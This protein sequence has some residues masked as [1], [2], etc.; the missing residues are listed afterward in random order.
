MKNIILIAVIFVVN[1]FATKIDK[2]VIA[3]PVATISHPIFHIIQE[4]ALK[5]IAE[6]VE[7]RLWQNPDEL[8]AILLKKEAHIVA[9]PTNVAANLY[10]K[11]ENIKLFNIPVWGILE[12]ITRDS[13]I[14]NINDLKNKEIVVP[15]RADMPDIMLQAIMKKE[16]LD[17]KK[18]FKLIYAPTPPDAMQMLILRRADN[19]LLAEPA[20]SM[21]MR[22]T[23]SFPLKLIAPDIYRSVNLQKEWGRVYGTQAKVPQAG[24]AALGDLDKN[25]I[26]R[27]NDEYTKSLNWYKSNPIEAG[28]LVAKN[29]DFFKAEAISDSIVNV[30]LESKTA[31]ESKKDLYDFFE[32]LKEIEPK[33]I[34]S[35]IPDDNFIW[36]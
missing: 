7:F 36:E 13:N 11:G 25:V 15:F 6:K 4:E 22:K 30:Q 28:Q 8:R 19:V 33:L 35:K 21:A 1:L 16:G 32:V 12:I 2:L 5:D 17:P 18:D 23:G 27:F 26:E 10:N 9:I 31:I 3:G 14:K 34:G 20:T 24:L 29:I